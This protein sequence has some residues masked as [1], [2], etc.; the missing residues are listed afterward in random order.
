MKQTGLFLNI[1]V[2]KYPIFKLFIS[3]ENWDPYGYFE[4]KTIFVRSKGAEIHA[5]GPAIFIELKSFLDPKFFWEK[6]CLDQ[7]FFTLDPTFSFNLKNFGVQKKFWV[8]ENMGQKQERFWGP[9]KIFSPRK[10]G[11]KTNLDKKV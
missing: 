10:Y 9:E 4:Y 11:S 3:S 5:I 1:S 6:F 2:N 8:P 7:Q